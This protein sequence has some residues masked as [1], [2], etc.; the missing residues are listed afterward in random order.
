MSVKSMN[1]LKI[2][3]K[4][5][6]KAIDPVLAY[7]GLEGT[8][9]VLLEFPDHRGGRQTIIGLNP[10][11]QVRSSQNEIEVI[12]QGNLTRT[13]GNPLETL[14]DLTAKYESVQSEIAK[15]IGYFGY[16]FIRNVENIGPAK[17]ND[18]N[19]YDMNFLFHSHYVLIQEDGPAQ[20]FLVD[21]EGTL[22]K[23]MAENILTKQIARLETFLQ[24]ENTEDFKVSGFISDTGK[25]HFENAVRRLKNHILEGDIFQAVLSHRFQSSFTGDPFQFFKRLRTYNKSMYRYY[26]D[27]GTYQIAGS[28]PERLITVQENKIL[29]NPIAGTRRRGESPARDFELEKELLNDEK[30][31]AEHYML[32]DL[33]RNDLGKVSKPSTVKVTK[34]MEIEKYVNV[35]HLVSDVEGVLDEQVHFLD[36]VASSLPAGTV[37]GAPKIK[38]M[39]LLNGIEKTRRGIYGGGIGY[40]T[41]SGNLDLALTIRTMVFTDNKAYLQAGAGIVHDS[42]PENEWNETVFKAQ[43]LMEALK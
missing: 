13:Y 34:L 28:S 41:H 21:Y 33:A 15:G 7:E 23:E 19:T 31:R 36:T 42:V 24:M 20:Y 40:F 26:M 6:K 12:K 2:Y 8:N 39:Q 9:K 35:M 37:S 43:G 17:I 1:M 32:V 25:E 11:I 10:Y 38:A 4:E 30:E 18:V 5:I 22:G 3:K 16:D 14:K 27:F 29:S